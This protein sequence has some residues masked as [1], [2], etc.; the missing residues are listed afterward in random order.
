[1]LTSPGLTSEM[2]TSPIVP[3]VGMGATV[4][5]YSDRHAGTIITVSKSGKRV[6]VQEDTATRTDKNGMSDAQ[7]YSYE[8][9]PNGS[10][11]T[12][13]KRKNGCWVRVGEGSRSG[14]GLV[15]GTRDEHY[16]YSF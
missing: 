5:Y 3:T 4:C 15:L 14:T 16:D 6:T 8:P 7:A 2:L 13:S 10:V 1:M 11:T 12:F 9:N